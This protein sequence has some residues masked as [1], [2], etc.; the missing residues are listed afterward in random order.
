MRKYIG[1]YRVSTEEQRKGN[2]SLETQREQVRATAEREGISLVLELDESHSGWT[3]GARP[4][5]EQALQLM[6]RDP[7]IKGIMVSRVD[8]LSR[9]MIDGATVLE[10]LQRSIY[11]VADGEIS[12]DDP[13]AVLKFNILLATSKHSSDQHSKR[14]QNGMKKRAEQGYFTSVRPFGYLVDSSTTPTSSMLDPDRAHLVQELFEVV[15]SRRLTLVEAVKWAKNRGLR[16]RTGRSL[17][18]GAVHF[19]LTNPAYYGM[20][21][22][23]HGVF[24]GKHDAIVSKELFDA[25]QEILS[26]GDGASVKHSNPFK[27]ILICAHCG[28][29]L[30]LTEKNKGGKTYRYYHCYGPKSECPRPSF[31]EQQLSDSLVSVLQGI[32]LPDEGIEALKALVAESQD[33]DHAYQRE[34]NARILTLQAEIQEKKDLCDIAVRKNLK[35]IIDDQAYTQVV[36]E[37][38]NEIEEIHQRIAELRSEELPRFVNLEDLFEL[39]KQ[40][41]ELYLLQDSE[42]RAEMLRM[43]TSNCLLSTDSIVPIYRKPFSGVAEGLN[44][45]NWWR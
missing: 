12:P 36:K 3:P 18:K 14:V 32:C 5:F 34:R 7:T 20:I 21:K 40:G 4:K 11:S 30:T 2:F 23:K 33:K 13:S 8:R 41:P 37:L 24:P 16:T 42:E 26:R 10:V 39:L 28:R 43:I 29:H 44:S 9:N 6:Q 15:R 31:S 35:G 27:G 17:S 19:I 22:S 38:N 25:V 45:G 1:Y